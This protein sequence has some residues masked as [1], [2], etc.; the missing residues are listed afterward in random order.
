MAEACAKLRSDLD[1]RPEPNSGVIVKDPVTRGFYRFTPVQ[2]S[3]LELM[4]GRRDLHSIAET[5]SRKHQTEVLEDQ[6]KDFTIKLRSLLLLDHAYCW[7][8]L[9]SRNKGRRKKIRS[10]LAMKFYAFNPD[11]LLSR[12]EKNLRFFFSSGFAAM[13]WITAFISLILTI[14]NWES[15]LVSLGTVFSLYSIPLI[16][17]V[18]FAIMTIHEFAHGLTLKHFGGKV[19][20]MGFMVLYF[21]PAFYC[22]VS[23]A[24]ML[25]KRERILIS[26]A[27][28][29]IQIFIWAM[30]TIA[31]RL[32]APETFLSRVCIIT[33]AFCGIQTLLNFNPLIRLDGYYMLSDYI[34]V[35]NLRSKAIA[36]VK[37]RLRRL[38]LGSQSAGDAELS[39][40]HR[41]LFFTYGIASSLFTIALVAI[42][43]QRLGGWFIREYH[44]WGIVLTSV[45]FFMIVPV[46]GNKNAAP[47]E[48]PAQAVTVRF[49]KLPIVLLI[50]IILTACSFLPWELKISGDFTIMASKKIEV[51][52]QVEGTLK[53]IHVEQGD[54]VP[55]GQLLAEME[56]LELSNSYEETKG[57][58]A[59]QRAS[60]DLLNAGSRPEEIDKARRQVDTKRA[61]L[62]NASRIQE[63][64]AVLLETV[65]KKE[66]ELENARLTHERTQ[67]LLESGLIAKNEAD[68]AATAYEVQRK[69]LSEARGQLK[70]LEEQTDRS[71]DIKRKELAQ[72]ESELTILR[73][74]S[75]KESIRAVE[76]QVSKLA[77]KLNIIDRQLALLNIRSP[78]EGVVATSYLQNRIGDFLEKGDVF[79]EI[80]SE[81]TVIVEM[82]VPEKEIGDVRL[83]LPIT[84]KVRGYPK[85]WYEARVM[86]IAPIAAASGQERSVIVQGA[87]KNPDGSLKAGMTGVGKILC[88][89]RTV[90]EIATRRAVRWLR[91]EFWE[92]LP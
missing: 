18:I 65:A 31:W 16:V 87:L 74:G 62:Y 41:R 54:Q 71:Q 34:E 55:K 20:E 68:R 24:W 90:F 70:I 79:C 27:G 40:K 91:T 49:G 88:G 45:L 52:P 12:L 6:L 5:V 72:A 73:A 32:L 43:F 33:I 30:A 3:V 80:V 22:N 26:F 42:M 39:T 36:Y 10:L 37:S 78:I 9:E 25:K 8:R 51:T 57:E 81:G 64:R 86:S 44:A 60:L 1:I 21:I 66:A 29:Y 46:A 47:S 58:L 48:K 75:R 82:P 4:D 19:E 7:A 67:R 83:G 14:S 85:R 59:S 38:F 17:A 13:V 63:A 84:I 77:E 76:S 15:L 89:K 2:A 11:K 69:E 50:L 23:D 28:G 92:Y 56:N 53:R 35:P 61:E